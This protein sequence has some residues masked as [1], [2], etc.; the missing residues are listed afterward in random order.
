MP[1]EELDLAWTKTGIDMALATLD[2]TG[3]AALLGS[4]NF[5]IDF[6]EI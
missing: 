1:K 6:K 5:Q 4:L 3:R 2:W